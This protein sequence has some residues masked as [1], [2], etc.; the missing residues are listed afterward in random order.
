MGRDS[1][2][3]Q[4][5]QIKQTSRGTS[6]V[7]WRLVPRLLRRCSGVDVAVHPIAVDLLSHVSHKHQP[8]G[9]GNDVSEGKSSDV[10]LK[11]LLEEVSQHEHRVD[12]K[13]V[14]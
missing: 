10:Q 5:T 11:G 1:R 14:V 6:Y 8:R 3:V 9:S 12:R 4:L 2:N 13:S 7:P